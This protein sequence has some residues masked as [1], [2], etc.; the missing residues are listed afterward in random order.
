[1][2]PLYT[3]ACR[4]ATIGVLEVV[5]TLPDMNSPAVIAALAAILQ[6]RLGRTCASDRGMNPSGP[7]VCCKHPVAHLLGCL[8]EG[9]GVLTASGA[10]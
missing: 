1:M 7:Y 2:L 3:E 4:A 5:Q 9:V 8:F 6:V 10:V